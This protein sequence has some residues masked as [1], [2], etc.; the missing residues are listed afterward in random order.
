MGNFGNIEF[1]A[2]RIKLYKEN[3]RQSEV[4]LE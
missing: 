3:A 4:A 2:G 1:Y